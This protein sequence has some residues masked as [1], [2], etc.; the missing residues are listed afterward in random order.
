M[1]SLKK[2]L[3]YNVSYQILILI[4]PFI[5]APYVSRVLGP[6]GLGT[7]S[8]MTATTKVFTMV[9]AMGMTSY[10]NRMI[11]QNRRSKEQLS[12]IFWDLFAFQLVI[13]SIV[14]L[15]FVLYASTVGAWNYGAV[16]ACQLPYML[17]AV[18][19]VSWFFFGIE[20]FKGIVTRNIIVKTLTTAAVFA[21]VNSA[22][23]VWVYTLI[24]AS[25]F[26]AG[27]LCLW[28]F[29]RSKVSLC[30]PRWKTVFRH[31]KPNCVLMVSVISLSIYAV[32]SKIVL[33]FFSDTTNVGYYENTEKIIT[34]ANNAAGAIGA[35]MLPRLANIKVEEGERVMQQYMDKSMHYIM[36]LAIA[37]CF[38]IAGIGDC[39]AVIYF[40]PEFEACGKLLMICAPAIIFYAWSNIMRN[41]YLLPNSL[42]T[43]FVWG[44]LIAVVVNV[45]INALLSPRYGAVGAAVAFAGAQLSELV[46]QLWRSRA[47]LPIRKYLLDLLPFV[48][49]GTI[50]LAY[51]WLAGRW[52]ETGITLLLIQIGGG[53][54]LYLSLTAVWLWVKKDAMLCSVIKKLKHR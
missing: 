36:I 52:L 6:T 30:R 39:F 31:F 33:E 34:I 27:Q 53:A 38:G 3:A 20:D 28:P 48:F 51:C 29:L 19:D 25:S 22:D 8:V 45:A 21:F 40:G 13:S 5:T 43:I 9:A 50:M 26:L 54:L 7:Y 11:A 18:F 2:N 23:D 15:A 41:Q 44:T 10:G 46:Y 32:L 35:V 4:V 16:I 12:Q 1:S 14:T 17:S 37:L 24:N 47:A 49:F 42:D